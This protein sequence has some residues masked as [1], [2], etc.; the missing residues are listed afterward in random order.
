MAL[1][2]GVEMHQ[3]FYLAYRR[4]CNVNHGDIHVDCSVFIIHEME[5]L[6]QYK[7]IDSSQHKRHHEMG[8]LA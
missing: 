5:I 1:L 2:R 3:T 6:C 4:Q 7:R 8:T